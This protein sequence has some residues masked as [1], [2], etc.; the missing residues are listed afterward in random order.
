MAKT[1]R[2]LLPSQSRRMKALGERL[3]MAR[4]RRMIS[5]EILA[6][7][8][9]MNRRTLSRIEAGDA[10]VSMRGYFGVLAALQL[11]QDLDLLARDDELG[12]RLQ[13]LKLP[14]RERAPRRTRVEKPK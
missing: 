5:A 6:S 13:D 10:S 3:R 1:R 11:D 12:R 4:L 7:R 8:A 14:R 9:G 2:I